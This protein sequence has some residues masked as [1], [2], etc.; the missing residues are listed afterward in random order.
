MF[1]LEF[2]YMAA[3]PPCRAVWMCLKELGVQV[4]MRHLDMYKK[5]EHTQPWFVKLNPQHMVPTLNDN[6][7]VLW[8]SRA[9][10]G[11]LVTKYG[12]DDRL[13]PRDPEKRAIVDRMLY[14]DIGTLYRAMIDY[15]Q[16]ILYTGSTGDPQKA[17]ALK[18]SLDYLDGYLEDTEYA[19]GEFLSIADFAILASVTHLDGLEYS[20]KA[21]ENINRWA[22]KLKSELPYYKECNEEGIAMFKDWVKSRREA[23][24]A[25]A[26]AEAA[27][28]AQAGRKNSRA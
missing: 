11:Y 28:A 20:Y 3:S 24:A 16:P 15:F 17:N 21:Y 12:S 6:G 26:A 5:A 14:F 7:F 13:Y 8:E 25:A 27:A 23:H 18:Q 10:M 19:A 2:I 1:G 4:D 22:N 9:I